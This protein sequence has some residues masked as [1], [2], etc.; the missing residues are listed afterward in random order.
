MNGQDNRMQEVTADKRNLLITA[1]VLITFLAFL[2]TLWLRHNFG[3]EYLR[4]HAGLIFRALLPF[5]GGAFLI[6]AML[7]VGGALAAQPGSGYLGVFLLLSGFLFGFHRFRQAVRAWR[8]T[9]IAYEHV[10]GY[11][12]KPNLSLLLPFL[13][14]TFIKMLLEPALLLIFAYSISYLSEGLSLLFIICA[15]CQFFM[16]LRNR[17]EEQQIYRIIKEQE[18]L[19]NNKN[20]DIFDNPAI[21]QTKAS[22]IERVTKWV[23]LRAFSEPE[24]LNKDKADTV[25]DVAEMNEKLKS[26]LQYKKNK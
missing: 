1:W 3:S 22:L 18:V 12:G 7:L 19:T 5:N 13:P 20:P 15:F 25:H 24:P 17:E 4:S 2:P 21:L 6:L 23:S 8:G 16:V 11:S 9:T 14:E 10:R 26:R